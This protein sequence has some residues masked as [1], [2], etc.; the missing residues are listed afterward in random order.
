MTTTPEGRI[1][2]KIK[3]LLDIQNDVYYFMPISTG[4]GKRTVDYLICV[5]GQFVAVEAKRPGGKATSKQAS[6]LL[7][8]E[9][10]GGSTFVVNDEASLAELAKFLERVRECT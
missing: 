6:V 9:N 1:K 2:N 8:I 3:K 5:R 7:E 10:A 4:F